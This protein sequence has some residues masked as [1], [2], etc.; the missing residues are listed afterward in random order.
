MFETADKPQKTELKR[1]AELKQL[2]SL[3]L[4]LLLWTSE[5]KPLSHVKVLPDGLGF[6][7]AFDVEDRGNNGDD[8][9][10]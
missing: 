4:L 10:W 3:L 6:D 5:S 1:A 9:N 2:S 7:E 8:G